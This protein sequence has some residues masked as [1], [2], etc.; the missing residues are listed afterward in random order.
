MSFILYF[1]FRRFFVSLKTDRDG[2]ILRKG[3]IIRR[4]YHVPESAITYISIKRSLLLRFL[5]ARKVTLHTLS[6]K[7]DFYLRHDEDID[8]ISGISPKYVLRPRFRSIVAGAFLHTRAL[9]G[10]VVFS[11]A[12][13]RIGS[14]FG[15]GY[16]DSIISAINT[17]ATGL[18]NLLRGLR[19]TVPR[20]TAVV[21]VFVG[22]AW[23]FLFMRNL[24]S[25]LNQRIEI[26][27]GCI[28]TKHGFFTLYEEIFLKNNL[29]AVVCRGSA[30][31]MVFNAEP[32][33]CFGQQAVPPL[34]R[35]KM[36]TVLKL[37]CGV[38]LKEHDALPPKRSV[39]GHI[40]LPLGWGISDA[41]M[42]VASY[43]FGDDPVLHTILWI[44]LAVCVWHIMLFYVFMRRTGISRGA[45]VVTARRG[46]LLFTA[47]LCNNAE[48][49]R[50]DRNLFQRYNGMCD[51]WVACRGG[52]RLKL[53]GMSYAQI[54]GLL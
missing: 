30:A 34:E 22:A 12:L 9:G 13:T 49:Y 19:I 18:D 43:Y 38:H 51:V 35:R 41:L 14:I 45:A 37:F 1:V 4:F 28:R 48:M 17:T 33:Y 40:A 36:N 10:V 26:S 7:V 16:Y 53:R 50:F 29:G 27:N 47:I 52:V 3:L 24:G 11:T 46:S 21:A 31:T 23:L 2:I 5:R 42:L 8:I 39:M 6:G 20:I 32:L 25:G 15:G 54:S 44:A